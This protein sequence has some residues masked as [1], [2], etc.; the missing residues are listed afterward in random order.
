MFLLVMVDEVSAGAVVFCIV[1][2]ARKYLLLHHSSESRH[3]GFPKGKLENDEQP[4]ET[5]RREV[6]EEAGITTLTFVEGFFKS[7]M[8]YYT[9][10]DAK[11]QKHVVY[12]LAQAENERVCLS[13]EHIGYVWLTYEKAHKTLTFPSTKDVLAKAEAFLQQ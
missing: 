8:Y 9:R 7:I 3:W 5:A 2:G 13:D 4:L 1:D 11:I 12:F 10:G 6:K